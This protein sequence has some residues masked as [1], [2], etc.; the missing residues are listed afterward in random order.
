MPSFQY[1]SDDDETKR[2]DYQQRK[3]WKEQQR[4]NEA[5]YE[6]VNEQELREAQLQTQQRIN[7]ELSQLAAISGTFQTSQ[8]PQGLS[9]NDLAAGNNQDW[10]T[11]NA[12]YRD[13]FPT[14]GGRGRRAQRREAAQKKRTGFE[15]LEENAGKNLAPAKYSDALRDIRKQETMKM[16]QEFRKS[17]LIVPKQERE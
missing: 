2:D 6:Q 16:I 4:E 13:Y 12:E 11:N 7:D 5:V 1:D 14:L 17:E 10:V 9:A 15:F 8:N 3:K